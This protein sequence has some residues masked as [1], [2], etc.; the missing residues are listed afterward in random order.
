[1]TDLIVVT[2]DMYDLEAIYSR[3]EVHPG[4]IFL[5]AGQSKLRKLAYLR[6]MFDLSIDELEGEY[7][8]SEAILVTAKDGRNGSVDISIK[9]YPLPS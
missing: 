7:R 2:N 9:Q 3:L 4:I 5:T 1:M 6:K 8:L